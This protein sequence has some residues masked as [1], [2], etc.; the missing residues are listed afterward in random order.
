MEK[1]SRADL[2]FSKF[3]TA[4]LDAGLT[5]AD[6]VYWEAFVEGLGGS[7]GFCRRHAPAAVTIA[8]AVEC[9]ARWPLTEESEW[10][11]EHCPHPQQRNSEA[12]SG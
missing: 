5:C 4:R 1:L 6:C 3:D 9:E 11:G 8:K 7:Y 10:C 12:I 2:R